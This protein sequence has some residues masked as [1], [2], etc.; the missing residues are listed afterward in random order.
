MA[1]SREL[2]AQAIE[3][4]GAGRPLIAEEPV[5]KS[6]RAG[7]KEYLQAEI[8]G[9]PLPALQWQHNGTDLPGATNARLWLQQISHS[10][11]GNY[12]LIAANTSGSVT[13]AVVA[14]TVYDAATLP[15]IIDQ[16]ETVTGTNGGRTVLG[17]AVSSVSACTYQWQFE[18]AVIPGATNQTLVL[19]NISGQNMGEYSVIV[20]NAVGSVVSSAT[21]VE[22]PLAT[23]LH[24]EFLPGKIRL[25]VSALVTEGRVE[26]SSDLANWQTLT[27]LP[28]STLPVIIDDPIN[29]DPRR[30]YRIVIPR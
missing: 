7:G 28:S 21:G 4:I 24:A 12:R 30:F 13:S 6:V 5:S 14:L 17:A 16:L 20:G 15:Q 1:A 10:M 27:N 29:T 19:D 23:A 8:I 18:G 25:T 11:T 3:T 22:L 9:W 26:Y 2:I